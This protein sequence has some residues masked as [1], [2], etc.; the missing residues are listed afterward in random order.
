MLCYW[1]MVIGFNLTFVATILQPNLEGIVFDLLWFDF[2]GYCAIIFIPLIAL[3][4]DYFINSVQWLVNPSA[5]Q[6]LLL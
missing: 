2:K 6:A 1:V 5:A 4:L 3:T